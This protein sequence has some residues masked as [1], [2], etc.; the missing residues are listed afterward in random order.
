MSCAHLPGVFCD[1]CRWPRNWID[2]AQ[3]MQIA[4]APQV[5]PQQVWTGV[6]VYDGLATTVFREREKFRDALLRIRQILDGID[7]SGDEDEL[8]NALDEIGAATDVVDSPQPGNGKDS[9]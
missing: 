5:Y 8:S 9:G 1:A 4:A 6:T 2:G 3:P 7:E